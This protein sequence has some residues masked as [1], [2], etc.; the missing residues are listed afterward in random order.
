MRLKENKNEGSVKHF[1]SSENLERRYS[2][3][4]VPVYHETNS[5]EI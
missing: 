3:V 4:G 1:L 2:Y 5:F